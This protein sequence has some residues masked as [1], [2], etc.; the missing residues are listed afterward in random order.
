MPDDLSIVRRGP[1]NVAAELSAT[2]CAKCEARHVGLCDALDDADLHFLA[3]VARRSTANR[4][5]VFITEGDPARQF[6][7]IN[8]GTAKL[9]KDLPDGRRQIIGFV[10]TGD[11]VGLAADK[12]YGFSAEALEPI[13]YCRFDRTELRGV[14]GRFP[15]IER[16][17]LDVAS[18]ELVIAQE[19]MLLL[20][21]KTAVERVASFLDGWRNRAA[22]CANPTAALDLPMSRS[23]LAD[24]LGL[25]IETVSRALAA[26]R[27]QNI[28]SIGSDHRIAILKPTRLTAIS[29]AAE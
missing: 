24:F 20:G 12:T 9:Y 29:Q 14:F 1:I 15:I 19:Q 6:F 5:Q 22:P 3:G 16:R 10:S 17:L 7:N 28:V 27:K 4:G 26:L 11:F 25:T 13:Q 21:R 18:H 23:E 2:L 8:H